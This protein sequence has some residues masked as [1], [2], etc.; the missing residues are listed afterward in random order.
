MLGTGFDI[1][2]NPLAQEG[3]KWQIEI[4]YIAREGLEKENR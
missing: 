1:L 2:E 4:G 3:P